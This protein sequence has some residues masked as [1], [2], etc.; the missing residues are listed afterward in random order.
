MFHAMLHLARIPCH[1][2]Y[3]NALCTAERRSGR[4]AASK[5]S[6]REGISPGFCVFSRIAHCIAL[7]EKVATEAR[8]A[9]ADTRKTEGRAAMQSEAASRKREDTAVWE[10]AKAEA[11]AWQKAQDEKAEK[12]KA[13]AA[14]WKMSE[15]IRMRRAAV[16]DMLH[17]L[18]HDKDG[19]LDKQE[20]KAALQDMHANVSETQLNILLRFFD[21]GGSGKIDVKEFISKLDPQLGQR[22]LQEATKRYAEAEKARLEAEAADKVILEAK[23]VEAAE[24]ATFKA[25]DAKAAENFRI[26]AETSQNAQLEAE[27]GQAG[28]KARLELGPAEA[29]QVEVEAIEKAR[30]EVEVEAQIADPT[31]PAVADCTSTAF[32]S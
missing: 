16:Y 10:K 14:I 18:V 29:S 8:A 32:A 13:D 6:S 7:Q 12:V 4:Q 3:N 30:L 19:M 5:R 22:A 25:E 28:E 2:L 17:R 27:Q 31:F 9:A 26:E 24:G 11:T 15:Y 20:L 21:K 23:E 1:R